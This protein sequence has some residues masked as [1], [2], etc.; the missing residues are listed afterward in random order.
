MT[1]AGDIEVGGH[2]IGEAPKQWWGHDDYEYIATVR[3]PHKK[4]LLLALKAAHFNDDASAEARLRDLARQKNISYK[5]LTKNDDHLL[6]ALIAAVFG[7]DPSA[8]SRFRDFARD[9][10]I[11]C[12]WFTWP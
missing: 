5:R 10:D 11:P 8:V 12:E 7:D 1:K 9:N 3:K 2:D 6:I 4:R